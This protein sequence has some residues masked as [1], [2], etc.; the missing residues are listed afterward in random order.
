ML[1]AASCGQV[2]SHQLAQRSACSWRV[3]VLKYPLLVS[4]HFAKNDAPAGV[5]AAEVGPADVG[6]FLGGAGQ[7][8]GIVDHDRVGGGAD[9][10]NEMPA[11]ARRLRVQGAD[12]GMDGEH[13]Q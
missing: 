3:R 13:Q 4:G 11:F 8:G 9:S 1:P 12:A 2:A 7:A 5:E 10:E 6:E